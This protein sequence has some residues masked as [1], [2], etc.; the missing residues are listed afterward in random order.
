LRFCLG[1]P[2]VAVVVAGA[3]TAEQV[4]ANVGLL[5]VTVPDALWAALDAAGEP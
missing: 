2:G 4:L 5:R 3:D 1:A